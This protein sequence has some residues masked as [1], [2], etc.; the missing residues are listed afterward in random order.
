[1]NVDWWMILLGLAAAAA[2]ALP[3]LL[4]GGPVCPHCDSTENQCS[5]ALHFSGH[6]CCERCS[7]FRPKSKQGS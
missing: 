1:M 4:D 2:V 6:P 7:H 5:E 3:F